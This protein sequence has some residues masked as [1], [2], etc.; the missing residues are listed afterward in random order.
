MDETID[1]LV[2]EENRRHETVV[3]HAQ[4]HVEILFPE[5]GRLEAVR[6][7]HVH[8]DESSDGLAVE[9]ARHE[10]APLF[11]FERGNVTCD[12]ACGN[13]NTNPPPISK[14][15]KVKWHVSVSS[16]HVNVF[17]LI[18]APIVD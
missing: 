13:G 5:R 7:R 15:S 3:V 8:Y 9:S 2:D 14:N 10:P 6:L 12:V 16:G 4:L 11:T 1:D 17:T 18:P